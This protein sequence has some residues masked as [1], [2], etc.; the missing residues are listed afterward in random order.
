[1]IVTVVFTGVVTIVV[2]LPFVSVVV[3]DV[4]TVPLAV[5]KPIG[6]P[7]TKRPSA[8]NTVATTAVV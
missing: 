2:A 3:S 8:V 6:I 1:M 4:E 5:E 7:G